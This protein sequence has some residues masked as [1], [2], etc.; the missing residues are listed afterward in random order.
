MG[1]IVLEGTPYHI[2][3]FADYVGRVVGISD[4]IKIDQQRIDAFGRATDDM[5]RIHVDPEFA[6]L[7]SPFGGIIAHGFLTLSM[8]THLSQSAEMVPDGVD[9][10]INL[11]FE[12]VRFLAPVPVDTHIRM[13]ATAL[14]CEHRPPGRW[15]FKARCNIEVRETEKVALSA[16]WSVLFVRTAEALGDGASSQLAEAGG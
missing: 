5:N 7:N 10:G 16:I 9:Y 6:R 11:G 15:T 4:W 3:H 14:G 8:L 2:D 12:R 1:R 13:K